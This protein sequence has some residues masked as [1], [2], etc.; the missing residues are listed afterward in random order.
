MPGADYFSIISDFLVSGNRSMHLGLWDGP[1]DDDLPAAQARLDAAVLSHAALRSGMVV[2][3]VG[4]GVG[5]TL[6]RVNAV[7]PQMRLIGVNPDAEQLAVAAGLRARPGSELRWHHGTAARLPLKTDTADVVLSVEAA[8]HFDS[9]AAFLAEA[10][11]VLRPGGRLVLTDIVPTDAMRALGAG[12]AGVAL[13]MESL[14]QRSIGPIP[15]VWGQRPDWSALVAA[16]GGR[17]LHHRDLTPQTLPSYRCFLTPAQ[18]A[19]P[20]WAGKGRLMD[21]GVALLEWLQSEGYVQVVLLVI[22]RSMR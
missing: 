20:G 6:A 5:G 7:H 21:E 3:D 14:L 16:A 18:Q 10:L 19:G 9:R 22:T 15:D 4:C 2:V 8:F 1:P 12:P 17:L 11:R 13:A